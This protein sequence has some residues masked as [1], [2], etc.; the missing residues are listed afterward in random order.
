M[1]SVS[2]FRNSYFCQSLGP[3]TIMTISVSIFLAVQKHLSCGGGGVCDGVGHAGAWGDQ[4]MT[5]SYQKRLVLF[6]PP[7]T[8]ARFKTIINVKLS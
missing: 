6:H 8:D 2:G 3:E 4:Y 7:Y 5:S 1:L